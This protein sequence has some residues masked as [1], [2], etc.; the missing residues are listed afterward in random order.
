MFSVATGLLHVLLIRRTVAEDTFILSQS[1]MV[2][3][4]KGSS[5]CVFFRAAMGYDAVRI[6]ETSSH[7]LDHLPPYSPESPL[8]G[9]GNNI[10]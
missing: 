7:D 1:D 2:I 9:C 4:T 5:A 10:A 8:I 3:I 6:E